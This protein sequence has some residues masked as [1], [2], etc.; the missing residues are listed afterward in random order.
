[1]E[2]VCAAQR[3]NRL[4]EGP[5][6][7]ASEGRLY[8]LDIES[9]LLEWLH[10]ASG[11]TGT[12]PLPCT[13]SAVA[14]R[15]KGGLLLGSERGFALFDPRTGEFT[16]MHNPEPER[17]WNRSNDGHADSMGRFWLGTMDNA[18]SRR[19]GAVYRLDPDWTCTRVLD[20]FGIPNTLVCTPDCSRIYIADSSDRVLFAYDVEPKT[21]VLGDRR[22]IAQTVDT[23][24]TPDGSALDAEGCLWN[25]QWGGWRIVRYT[26]E[27]SIDRIIILP[28]EQPTSCAFGGETLSQLFITTARTGLSQEALARQPLAGSLLVC[29]PGVSGQPSALFTG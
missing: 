25:A 27:G 12:W 3:K 28:V 10:P 21:G 26:P 24:A 11:E 17:S 15:A 22:V 14:Q 7:V 4:G 2:I 23:N 6:W 1:M 5:L 13:V 16:L 18:Q 9:K 29:E 8:W 19:S 20:G